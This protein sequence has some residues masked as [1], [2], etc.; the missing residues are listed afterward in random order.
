MDRRYGSRD[1]RPDRSPFRRRACSCRESERHS[2]RIFHDVPVAAT[3]AATAT[4]RGRRPALADRGDGCTLARVAGQEPG[5][6]PRVHHVTI[7]NA[8]RRPD[9]GAGRRPR[10]FPA[11]GPVA[12][13]VPETHRQERERGDPRTVAEPQF[14]ILVTPGRPGP[15]EEV[16][17]CGPG[18]KRGGPTCKLRP[19]SRRRNDGDKRHVRLCAQGPTR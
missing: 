5:C 7:R 13:A 1:L 2:P 14:H 3:S 10:A 15:E 12:V 18:E 19:S 4:D 9:N 11:K 16:E 6:R 17:H 8:V